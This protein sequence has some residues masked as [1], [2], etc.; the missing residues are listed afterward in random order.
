MPLTVEPS[1]ML[2]VTTRSTGT[3]FGFGFGFG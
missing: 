1:A 2:C 3:G